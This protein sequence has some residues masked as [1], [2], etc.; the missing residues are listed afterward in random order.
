M[1]APGQHLGVQQQGIAPLHP[2]KLT[3]CRPLYEHAKWVPH[4]IS[5]SYL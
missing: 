3:Y 1:T 2:R 4:Q 5:F